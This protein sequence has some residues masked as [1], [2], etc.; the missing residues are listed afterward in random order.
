MTRVVGTGCA[1]SAVVAASC[2]LPGDRLDNVAA[3]CGWMKRAGSV[4]AS[5][6]AGPGSFSGAFIDALWN[7]EAQS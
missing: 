5:Q 6:S 4:A 2:S 1:L 7:L 3:A